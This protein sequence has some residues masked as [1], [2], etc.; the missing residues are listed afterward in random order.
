MLEG[1]TREAICTVWDEQIECIGR[2]LDPQAGQSADVCNAF[3]A[4]LVI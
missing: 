3:D 4:E 1:I 2:Y